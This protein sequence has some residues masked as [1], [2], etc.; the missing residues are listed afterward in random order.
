MIPEMS[1]AKASSL[2]KFP[3][4]RFWLY[5]DEKIP[6]NDIFINIGFEV[7]SEHLK[8]PLSH[9]DKGFCFLAFYYL[10][11]LRKLRIFKII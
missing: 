11:L 1:N 9:L 3:N 8:D 4:Q 7:I 10:L 2:K 5:I 6:L